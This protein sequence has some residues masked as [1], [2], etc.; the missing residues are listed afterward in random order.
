[1]ENI[2][3]HLVEYKKHIRKFLDELDSEKEFFN[4]TLDRVMKWEAVIVEIMNNEIIGI[5]GLEKKI[6]IFR[7]NVM[8]KKEFQGKG[9]GKLFIIELLKESSHN[10]NIMW[11]VISENNLASINL[12]LA[13]GYKVVGRR[14]NMYYFIAPLSGKGKILFNLIKALF[15]LMRMVDLIRR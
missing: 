10:H 13:M 12:H 11:A 5:A 2:T 4:L 8:L 15:P 9:L 7:S 14:Q 6:G 1:M 3:Y